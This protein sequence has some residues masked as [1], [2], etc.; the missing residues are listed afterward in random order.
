MDWAAAKAA[1][2]THAYI[3]VSEGLFV[4]P[5]FRENWAGAKAVGIKIG[6]YHYYRNHLRPEGQIALFVRLMGQD[7]GDRPPA[8]DIE[9]VDAHPVEDEIEEAL[10]LVEEGTKVQPVIYTG[11]WYWD[12]RFGHLAWAS[13][14][15]LWIASYRDTEPTLPADWSEYWLWQFGWG[16]GLD[17][18]A[19]STWIDLNEPLS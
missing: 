1:G 2:V 12:S 4:D 3:K 9:D 15:K 11:D 14:Y 6:G 17:Y 5:R 10:L 19:T 8:L 13:S 18:G 7:I 16:R